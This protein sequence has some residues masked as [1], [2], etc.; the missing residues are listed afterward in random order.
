MKN[1]NFY[2]RVRQKLTEEEYAVLVDDCD[3]DI[4]GISGSVST[5]PGENIKRIAKITR[6]GH[7]IP[8]TTYEQV[9]YF[10]CRDIIFKDTDWILVSTF[11]KKLLLFVIS[12]PGYFSATVYKSLLNYNY[13]EAF[14]YKM[15]LAHFIILKKHKKGF[16]RYIKP[17][18]TMLEA[19]KEKA[20]SMQKVGVS[21]ANVPEK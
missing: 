7:S 3:V 14:Y 15:A 1:R 10:Y 21:E 4:Q 19:I 16:Y 6:A 11:I 5:Y 20:N 9:L 18:T 13:M 17:S 8:F 12:R 2:S